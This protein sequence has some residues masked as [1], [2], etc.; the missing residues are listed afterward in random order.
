MVKVIVSNKYINEGCDII[1][2]VNNDERT[3]LNPLNLDSRYRKVGTTIAIS[4]S[5]TRIQQQ[6]T[7]G[8][9]KLIEIK[10]VQKI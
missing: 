8:Q 1:L 3:E 10:K 4:Y 9:G 6:G 5:E 2:I 7:C